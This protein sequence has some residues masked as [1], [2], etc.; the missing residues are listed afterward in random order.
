MQIPGLHAKPEAPKPIATS[1]TQ[2]AQNVMPALQ[3]IKS[4]PSVLL[5][6]SASLGVGFG[7]NI[8]KRLYN[9]V[10]DVVKMFLPPQL[11][12][13]IKH[14]LM[15]TAG[16]SAF[17]FVLTGPF[18]LPA[19]PMFALASLGFDAAATFISGMMRNPNAAQAEQGA[20]LALTA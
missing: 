19:L 14:T 2:V 10:K 11:G 18:H 20:K 17:S 16:L 13:T 5:T 7:W 9:G 12:K 6:K 8:T 1:A 4:D 15:W 3:T